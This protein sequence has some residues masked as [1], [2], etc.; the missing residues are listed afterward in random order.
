MWKPAL[1]QRGWLQLRRPPAGPDQQSL[2]DAH[3][4]GSPASH[5]MLDQFSG[6][7]ESITGVLHATGRHH[8][9]EQGAQIA[10]WCRNLAEEMVHLIPDD[11]ELSTGLHLLLDA[12]DSFLRA[13]LHQMD[14]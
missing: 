8:L 11:P 7:H 1:K 2:A 6:H 3:P 10:A 5:A 13:A 4:A 14:Q 12:R 9:P